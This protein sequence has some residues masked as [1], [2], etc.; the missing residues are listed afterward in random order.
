VHRKWGGGE[1]REGRGFG[2][3]VGES[4]LVCVCARRHEGAGWTKRVGFAG[5]FA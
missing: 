4:V 1:F 5:G 3:R 2:I